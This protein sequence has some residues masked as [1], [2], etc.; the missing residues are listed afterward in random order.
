MVCNQKAIKTQL[1]SLCGDLQQDFW[2]GIAIG[3][4]TE[5][6]MISPE[7]SDDYLSK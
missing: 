3:S 7:S 6:H 4:K 2:T 5:F 1:F